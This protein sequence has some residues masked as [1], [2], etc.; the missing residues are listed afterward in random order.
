MRGALEWFGFGGGGGW[1]RPPGRR[2]D[3]MHQEHKSF[4]IRDLL[5][6]VL[7]HHRVQGNDFSQAGCFL[8]PRDVDFFI[9][10]LFNLSV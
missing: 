8:F 10:F 5:G 3:T 9:F 2:A 6:D 1:R 4:L 7:D